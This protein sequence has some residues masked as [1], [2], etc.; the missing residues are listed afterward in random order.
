[1]IGKYDEFAAE[2]V[3]AEKKKNSEQKLKRLTN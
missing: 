2:F 1:L 3:A